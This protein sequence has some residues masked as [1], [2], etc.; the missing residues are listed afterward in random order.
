MSQPLHK[1]IQMSETQFHQLMFG[2]EPLSDICAVL[3][4]GG[5]ILYPTD[6]IWGVG[7]DATNAS[8]IEKIY[9]LKQRDPNKPLSLLASSVEMVKQYVE[10]LHP[11]VETLL[12]HH[13]RPLTVVYNK[14]KNLPANL[15]P[16]NGSI[17]IRIATDGF[18]KTLIEKFGKPIVTTSANLSGE[19]FPSHFG[20]VSSAIIS[21]VDYISKS[22]RQNREPGEPSVIIK[23]DEK[24]EI[25]FLRE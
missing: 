15:L 5:S 16:D 14:A 17:A 20:E 21:G 3:E 12:A 6:T 11:R 4:R 24:G 9:E 8:A 25:V 18:C 19:P 2:S 7:C 10:E 13:S 22:G 1:S 23:V